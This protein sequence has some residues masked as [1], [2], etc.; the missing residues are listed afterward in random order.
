[1][2][3]DVLSSKIMGYI[4][5]FINSKGNS[6]YYYVYKY[7]VEITLSS[8]LNILIILTISFVFQS[9]FLGFL[10]LFVIIPT[11]QFTGGFH[12]NS[13]LKC[14]IIFGL[15]Y[16]IVLLFSLY[17]YNFINYFISFTIL[18][19]MSLLILR[20]CPIK[21]SNKQIESKKQFMRNKLIGFSLFIL[22]EACCVIFYNLQLLVCCCMIMFTLYIIFILCLIGFIKEEVTIYEK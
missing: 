12:A 7:G 21:N 16:L 9:F 10:F 15:S 2:L 19:V 8:I 20:F 13:Y 4:E 22:F 5:S 1:M 3:I 6:K 17:A 11:R 14:N 18:T